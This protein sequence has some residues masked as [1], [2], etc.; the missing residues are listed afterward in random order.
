MAIIARCRKAHANPFVF[1]GRAVGPLSERTI[2]TAFNK[3]AALAGL[4]DIKPHDLRRAYITDAIGAGVPL[5]T[6]ADM[7]GHSTILMTA[8][9]AKAADGQVREAG[10]QLAAARKAKRGADVHALQFGRGRGHERI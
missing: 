7:V 10:T 5:P 1:A 4:Q 8:R 2:R 9:Y 6:V 3:T